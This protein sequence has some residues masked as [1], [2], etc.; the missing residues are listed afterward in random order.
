MHTNFK[1]E[2]TSRLQY[3][4]NKDFTIK[5]ISFR[6][7]PASILAAVITITCCST[8]VYSQEVRTDEQKNMIST[9]DI[10]VIES[11]KLNCSE[12]PPWIIAQLLHVSDDLKQSVSSGLLPA[13][14]M[15]L[16][17]LLADTEHYQGKIIALKTIYVKA[18]DVKEPLELAPGE[19]CWSVLLLD[20]KYCHAL[21]IFTSENPERFKK[22]QL[23]YALGVFL[24]TRLDKPEKGDA[25]KPITVPVMIGT[26]LPVAEEVKDSDYIHFSRFLVIIIGLTITYIMIR[27]YVG[28]KMKKTSGFDQIRRLER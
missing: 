14:P 8:I 18:S 13:S 19:Q 7:R 15:E 16:N 28:K 23:L 2:Q 6:S 26:L 17:D 3:T 4:A 12:I 5:K 22:N 9:T 20:V 21:Q 24:T 27:V 1:H 10:N 25:S 11:L